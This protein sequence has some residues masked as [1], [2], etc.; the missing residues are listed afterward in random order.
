MVRDFFIVLLAGLFIFSALCTEG[1]SQDITPEA[2]PVYALFKAI[3]QNDVELFKSAYSE[4]MK[5]EFMEEEDFKGDWQNVLG[6]Y[7]K[8]MKEGILNGGGFGDYE[9]KDFSFTYT[10]TDTEGE[11][12]IIFKGE[13]NGDLSVIKEGESWKIDEK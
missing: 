1:S 3:K 8:V 6:Y 4:R 11:I 5:A 9:L 10:G 12:T 2:R 13:E 7:S